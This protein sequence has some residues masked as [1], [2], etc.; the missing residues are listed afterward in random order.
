MDPILAVFLILLFLK[1]LV[2]LWLDWLNLSHVKRHADER[3][4]AL[5]EVIDAETYERSVKYTLTKGRF[6]IVNGVFDALIHGAVVATGLLGFA[7]R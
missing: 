2:S 6:G 1:T 7:F 4:D 3:P 5:K